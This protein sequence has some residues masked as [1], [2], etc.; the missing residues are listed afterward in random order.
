MKLYVSSS[1]TLRHVFA[2]ISIDRR[3]AT[4]YIYHCVGGIS[5][6]PRSV[7]PMK[8]SRKS[9][10]ALRALMSLVGKY[11]RGVVSVRELAE[12][13]DIPR[14]FLETI[15]LEMKAKGWVESVAGRDGGFKLAVSP[16]QLTMGQIVRHFDGILAP[17]SCVSTSHYEACSQEGV[18]RFRRVLLDVRNYIA[19]VMDGASL[20]TVFAGSIVQRDEVFSQE[21][22]YGDGI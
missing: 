3:C 5:I 18:C 8:L 16:E 22:L 14:K 13:N 19:R 2:Q 7:V 12:R 21:M 4:R 20:A 9:D 1:T 15:M 11:G 6:P 10:Y 17:I